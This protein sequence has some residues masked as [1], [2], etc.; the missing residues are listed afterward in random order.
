MRPKKMKD[1]RNEN[2][3]KIEY[4]EQ[5]YANIFDNLEEMG[6]I[7]ERHK[8]PK[9][10]QEEIYNTNSLI[11]QFDEN[12]LPSFHVLILQASGRPRVVSSPLELWCPIFLL[13]FL[14]A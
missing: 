12:F 13:V 6:E 1:T 11:S 10:T 14:S 9:L 3:T 4:Y 7:L 2:G 8:L 5:I